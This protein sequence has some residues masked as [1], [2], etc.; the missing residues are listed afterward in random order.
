MRTPA[1]RF[2]DARRT[3]ADRL[4]NSPEAEWDA[5][6]LRLVT[7]HVASVLGHAS[8]EAVD[9]R[10]PFKEAGFDSLTALELRNRLG[11]AS[12]LKLPSTLVF[13]H[14][15]PAA[16]AEFLR[17]KAV[18]GGTGR[19]G[20]DEEIDK[21]ESM[22]AATATATATAGDGGERERIS[23]RLRSLLAQLTDDGRRYDDP[24]S[25]TVE[26]IESASA[27]EIV[28]LIQKDLTESS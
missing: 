9:P 18:D 7:D 27:D 4:A 17:L 5:I 23:G 3:L 10:R 21:L 14:P 22:L 1:R 2:D 8:S 12:G 24:D 19:A 25:V 6:V 28:E 15:T 26:M 13:D 20:I 11:Q 16:V